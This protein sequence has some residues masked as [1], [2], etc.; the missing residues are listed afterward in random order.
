MIRNPDF[1]AGAME[2]FVAITHR[3]SDILVDENN[4]PVRAKVEVAGVVAHEMAHQWFGDMVTMK[5]WNNIWLNEGFATWMSSK[6]LEAWK[7]EWHIR[8]EVAAELN[9]AMNLDAQAVTR[10]IRAEANTPAEINEMF[11]G[12]TY[13]K[14]GSILRMVESY[15]GEE[16]FRQ[17]VH[18]YL[19][20]HIYGNATAEDFWNAQTATSHKPVDRIMSSFI[21][22]PG[23]PLL[24][25]GKAGQG[26]VQ[27]TQSRF[28][29]NPRTAPQGGT[30]QLW[31]VPVC[32]G[33]G[34]TKPSC[35]LLEGRQATLEVPPHAPFFADAGA[36]GYYRVR[37]APEDSKALLAGVSALSAPERV[38]VVGNQEALMHAGASTA[39]DYLALAA[40][41]KN[42]DSAEVLAGLTRGLE[43]LWAQVASTEAERAQLSKWIVATFRPRL[44]AMGDPA[45]GESD[46]RQELRARLFYLVGEFGRDPATIA[47]ARQLATAYLADPSKVNATLGE[48]AVLVAADHGDAAFF[49]LL[50]R[51]AETAKNPDIADTAL[52][53]LAD[54]ENPE[55]T[56]RALDYAASGKVRN[57]DSA[58]LFMIA[59]R[60]P[61][62][63]DTAWDYIRHN[64]PRVE[65]QFTMFT[66]A[67]LVRAT[68]SFCS[69]E[70]AAEVKQFFSEHKVAASANAM[71]RAQNSIRDCIDLRA[72]QE[73]SLRQWLAAHGPA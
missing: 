40:S 47:R 35:E 60:S 32:F 56:R 72:R 73:P 9:G 14:G 7:P 15:L 54:F 6:P 67:E 70:K 26:Q 8:E 27:V 71:V 29:L 21:T 36:A 61:E 19:Q 48:R 18:N 46:E 38:I 37:Y 20:A 1:E 25:F 69:E 44:E 42:D 68:G 39:G 64:W 55:L 43:T 59:L 30:D 11:D 57:Q 2:N 62:A 10:T 58:R 13:E 63:M 53:G 34:T 5:W 45:P 66:G 28:F 12:I 33:G 4:A 23:V 50:E 49:D 22:A 41:L 31:T 51:T 65:A 24:T 16:T 3:E 52:Y 17:G